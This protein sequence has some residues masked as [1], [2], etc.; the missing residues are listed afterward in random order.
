LARDQKGSR[1]EFPVSRYENGDHFAFGPSYENWLAVRSSSTPDCEHE[2]SM[3]HL[4]VSGRGACDHCPCWLLT[5]VIAHAILCVLLRI[6][7]KSWPRSSRA[8]E[9]DFQVRTARA[10]T[11]QWAL[12]C[13]PR[14]AA[15]RICVHVPHAQALIR[16]I[17]VPCPPGEHLQASCPAS[18]HA[19]RRLPCKQV[20]ACVC[21]HAH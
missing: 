3:A 17:P 16:S 8:S 11:A 5:T 1:T 6:A 21:A 2:G 10:W 20:F 19:S 15:G 14:N 4:E 12:E 13:W 18:N 7:L 9:D